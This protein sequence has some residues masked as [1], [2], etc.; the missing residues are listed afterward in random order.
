MLTITVYNH[1][2]V[3][4]LI[5]RLSEIRT[6]VFYVLTCLSYNQLLNQQ[7]YIPLMDITTLT[8]LFSVQRAENYS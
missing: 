8:D 6:T 1:T 7:V 5:Y 2:L 4:S 3:C